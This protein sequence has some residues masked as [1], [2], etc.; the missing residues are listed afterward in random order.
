M[1][2]DTEAIIIIIIIMIIILKHLLLQLCHVLRTGQSG[3][4]DRG[5]CSRY[6]MPLPHW[7]QHRTLTRYTITIL[8]FFNPQNGVK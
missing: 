1:C 4:G 3:H 7:D 8:Y 2:C 5:L 6:V